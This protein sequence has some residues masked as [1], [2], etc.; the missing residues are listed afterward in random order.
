MAGGHTSPSGCTPGGGAR[1]GGG[2]G[3]TTHRGRNIHDK[4]LSYEQDFTLL[5]GHLGGPRMGESSPALE[6]RQPAPGRGTGRMQPQLCSMGSRKGSGCGLQLSGVPSPRQA[7][8]RP[9]P[10]TEFCC[11]SR[12]TV[13]SAADRRGGESTTPWVYLPFTRQQSTTPWVYLPFTRVANKGATMDRWADL[14][15]LPAQENRVPAQ[16]NPRCK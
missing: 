16:V 4:M 3:C 10:A 8:G 9:W 13:R 11:F 6:V 14:G 5:P 7:L 1:S 15:R 12:P 2:R